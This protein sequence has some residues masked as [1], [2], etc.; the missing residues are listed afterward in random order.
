MEGTAAAPVQK[1]AEGLHDERTV[2]AMAEI[3][4]RQRRMGDQRWEDV[5]KAAHGKIVR[6]DV[7][8]RLELGHDAGGGHIVDADER[9]GGQALVERAADQMA[10]DGVFVRDGALQVVALGAGIR[11][12]GLQAAVRQLMLAGDLTGAFEPLLPREC[13]LVERGG[14]EQ[15]GPV[16]ELVEVFGQDGA[17][18]LVGQLDGADGQIG[19]DD[20]KK[21]I[22]VACG[23][24]MFWFD[25]ENSQSGLSGES[26]ARQHFMKRINPKKPS[27]PILQIYMDANTEKAIYSIPDYFITVIPPDETFRFYI[28]ADNFKRNF[29]DKEIAILMK[30][31]LCFVNESD[32]AKFSENLLDDSV[33]KLFIYKSDAICLEWDVLKTVLSNND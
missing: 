11:H 19:D 2:G 30:T 22:D 14:D 1:I 4:R 20:V 16:P 15:E 13:K 6:D 27:P 23:S 5:V 18:P 10:A 26:K 9:G 17:R 3:D 7:A 28:I 8:A 21:I 31:K 29:I 25:K 24:K 33:Y 12:Q 32:I